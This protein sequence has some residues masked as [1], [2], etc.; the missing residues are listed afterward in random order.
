MECIRESELRELFKEFDKNGDGKITREELEL[1][2][3]QLG[4]KPSSSQVDAIMR[5][6]DTDGTL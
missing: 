3:V 6:T 2:L 5:Q 4:E 1:V